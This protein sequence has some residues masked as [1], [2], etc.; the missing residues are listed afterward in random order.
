LSEDG[1]ARVW[2]LPADAR[3]PRE[4]AELAEVVSGRRVR[5]TGGSV[6]L[7]PDEVQARWDERR[8]HRP[9]D[10]ETPPDRVRT[11][12]AEEADRQERAKEW[13]AAAWHFGPLVEAPP[14]GP[15]VMARRAAVGEH[16]A[17]RDR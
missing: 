10:F 7:R 5:P 16:L 15:A 13:F 3:P 2:D 12:H 8:R 11:W 9:A 4:W 6:A 17:G 14:R 1:F